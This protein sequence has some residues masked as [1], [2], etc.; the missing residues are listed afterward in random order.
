M[1]VPIYGVAFIATGI[2]AYYSDKVP[3]WRGLIIACWLTVSLICSIVVCAVYNFT[4]R[5]VLLVVM[6]AG[7]WATNGGTLAYAS[8]AFAGMH[9]QARGVALAMVNALGNLAQIY[10]SVG[11]LQNVVPCSGMKL[12]KDA[13]VPL[14]G[15]R[16]PQIYHGVLCHFCDASSWRNRVFVLAYMV[17]SSAA[18]RPHS[19][20]SLGLNV[21]G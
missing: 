12:T 21:E 3:T 2:T 8:S 14:P 13:I 19:I 15:R 17:P 18:V 10:G 20:T 11:F 6:A 5:Y 4:A 1:T 16:W 9:P 7:L